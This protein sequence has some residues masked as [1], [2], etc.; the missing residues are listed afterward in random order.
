MD[1]LFSI[2]LRAVDQDRYTSLRQPMKPLLKLALTSL[3]LVAPAMAQTSSP[4]SM[5]HPEDYHHYVALFKAQE[6]EATKVQ[7]M[8]EWPWMA[9]NIPLFDASDKSF[10]EMYY[11]R[12]YAFQKHV[13]ETKRGFVITEWLPKPE[14]ADGFF[15]AL[16]DAAPF[17]LGEARW[18]RNPKIAS[19]DARYWLSPDGDPRKYSTP[20]SDSVHKV[21]LASGDMTLEND[22]LPAMIANYKAWDDHLDPAVG[23][24]WQIDTRDAMEKSI[25]GDGYR[26]PLNSY[27]YADAMAIA[28]IAAQDGKADVAAEY[29][30]KAAALRSLID[31]KLWNPKDQ[32]YEDLSP[33]ADSGIRKQKKFID[34]GTQLKLSGTRELIGYIPWEFYLPATDRAIAWK[35][36]LDPQGFAGKYG[37]TT[38]ERRS[39]RFRFASDDQC[40]WN[41][42]AWPYAD[43]QTLLALAN[44]L[45][46]SAQPYIGN[47]DYLQLFDNYVLSQHLTLANGKVIDWI[48]E[49]L[50]ADTDQW[51]A[52]TMLAAKNKQVGRGNYYNHS[53][54]ADPLITGLIGLRPR[55]DAVVELHP[56]L[57]ARAW[58]YFALDGLPYHGHLLAIVYDA[59]GEHYH[60]G[61]GL[62]LFVDGAKVA[63]RGTLGSI[64]IKLPGTN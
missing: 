22:L 20:I 60:R 13:V 5:L 21:A 54:F 63:S 56:L 59:T 25:G 30:A 40:T 43:T 19:D 51:I 52:K 64:E 6:V 17:H 55:A 1:G 62:T 2:L 34:P 23:L 47:K 46:R 58:S 35:Q 57:P 27:Q 37:P 48:D 11:F 26:T 4:F 9:A 12:W 16:P 15:G 3:L 18:L 24:Y 61:K 14:V 29:S 33:A 42:P 8:D 50:D 32:F 36:L 39:P 53:G 49:D 7:P 10:E 45:N 38:A 44:L 41:G 28:A 31:A